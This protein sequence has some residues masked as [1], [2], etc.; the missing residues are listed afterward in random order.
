MALHESRRQPATGVVPFW[1][2]PG[3]RGQCWSG[4][5]PPRSHIGPPLFA[6]S[7]PPHCEVVKLAWPH[8]AKERPLFRSKRD[9]V[10]TRHSLASGLGRF[11]WFRIL[12]FAWVAAG[13]LAM[14]VT[15]L[16][17]CY[18]PS[19]PALRA[20][21]R[22]TDDQPERAL[23]EVTRRLGGP[24][25]AGDALLRGELHAIAANAAV[26][27]SDPAGVRRLIDAGLADVAAIPA[28]PARTRLLIGLRLAESVEFSMTGK[29]EDATRVLTETLASVG[30]TMPERSCLLAARGLI[31]YQ[32][33]SLADA[34]ADA[35]EA[36]ETARAGG[37]TYARMNAAYLL[38]AIYSRAGLMP[39]AESMAGEALE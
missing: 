18:P 21:D 12:A 10:H 24:E 15:A 23:R 27:A 25:V 31:H 17:T 11:T 36:Y 6:N 30:P 7:I 1:R 33:R 5:E 35:I 8:R 13:L 14:P 34:G 20:L 26:Q 16:A 32:A 39:Q 29:A 4:A 37:D 19:N 2:I 38:A 9:R 22:D 28:G 3:G